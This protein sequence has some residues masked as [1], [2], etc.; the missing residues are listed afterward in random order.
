MCSS[1]A[2]APRLYPCDS[3]FLFR[4]LRFFYCCYSK[5]KK[6]K[7]GGTA[8]TS[9]LGFTSVSV[10]KRKGTCKAGLGGSRGAWPGGAEFGWWC[11][12]AWWPCLPR[13]CAP[14]DVAISIMALCKHD[15]AELLV[16]VATA[17]P[18]TGSE[19]AGQESMRQIVS[20]ADV[21]PKGV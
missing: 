8:G 3:A 17:W 4:G 9:G 21:W 1:Q 15:S 18:P 13:G 19:V 16:T 6:K 12:L 10:A 5:I 7:M 2:P 14:P 20:P 11:V